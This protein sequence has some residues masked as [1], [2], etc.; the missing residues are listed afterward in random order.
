MPNKIDNIIQEI[1]RLENV[2]LDVKKEIKILRRRVGAY[3]GWLTRYRKQKEELK[4][5]ASLL[6]VANR[7]ACEQ[8]DKL[9]RE[10]NLKKEELLRSVQDGK[11]AKEER[12]KA[13]YE[14]DKIIEK[15]ELYKQICKKANKISYSDKTYLIKEA[16]RLFFEEES[17]NQES[18]LI[19]SRDKPQMFTDPASINR[20][21][22]NG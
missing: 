5:E 10:L 1:K 17:V 14:L 7:M 15:I 4:K 11:K 20:S 13:I 22:S 3:K 12:D 6:K 19:N 2:T 8:R 16:E 21:L 9:Q 18:E